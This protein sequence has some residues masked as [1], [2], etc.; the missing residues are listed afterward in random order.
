MEQ[1]THYNSHYAWGFLCFFLVIIIFVWLMY[2]SYQLNKLRND[3]SLAL[4]NYPYYNGHQHHHHHRRSRS[5]GRDSDSS[6]SS[7]CA[8]S[9]PRP[10]RP[11]NNPYLKDTYMI[12]EKLNNINST[13]EIL[14]NRLSQYPTSNK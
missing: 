3:Y 2:L 8:S 10:P 1:Y 7:S 4:Y 12:N 5:R 14:N 9:R 6:D 11:A 13:V